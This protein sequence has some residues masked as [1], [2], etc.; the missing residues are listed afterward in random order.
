MAPYDWETA[1]QANVYTAA[2]DRRQLAGE[3]ARL[4]AGDQSANTE[5]PTE[6]P[7]R[8]NLA[9][10]QSDKGALAGATGLEPATFGVTGRRSNQLSY[11]PAGAVGS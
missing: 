5:C 3:A 4:L 8:K 9:L 7:H 2:A 10:F 11:A 6:L 1:A